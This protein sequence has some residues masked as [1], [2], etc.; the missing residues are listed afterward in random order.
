M[1]DP[2]TDRIAPLGAFRRLLRDAV[3][4]AAVEWAYTVPVELPDDDYVGVRMVVDENGHPIAVQ[5]SR[6]SKEGR[7]ET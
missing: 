5:F 6:L 1:I 4:H 7:E 2:Q 3:D